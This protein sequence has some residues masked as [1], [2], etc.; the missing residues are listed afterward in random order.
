[1]RQYFREYR[2]L[3]G[4]LQV[5]SPDQFVEAEGAIFLESTVRTA[6]GEA[7]VYDAFV[8]REGRIVFH[9]TGAK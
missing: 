5:L 6:L 9:F 1:M 7:R 4:R 3:L 2:K 8:L